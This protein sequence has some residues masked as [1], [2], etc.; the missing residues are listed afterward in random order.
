MTTLD[1]FTHN[2][3]RTLNARNQEI[4]R[5]NDQSVIFKFL[6][7]KNRHILNLYNLCRLL[8]GQIFEKKIYT[9]LISRIEKKIDL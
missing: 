5:Q 4:W 3:K 8:C 7:R 2:K 1:F 6:K 9:P